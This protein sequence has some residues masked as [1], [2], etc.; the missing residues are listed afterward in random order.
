M[1]VFASVAIGLVFGLGSVAMS[2]ASTASL[3]ELHQLPSRIYGVQEITML[4]FQAI[5]VV[6]VVS[7]A[8]YRLIG[9]LRRD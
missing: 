4:A 1:K 7:F 3:D 6:S 8:T 5:I 2:L 9:S